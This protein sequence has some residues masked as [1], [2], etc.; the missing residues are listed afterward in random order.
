MNVT[1]PTLSEESLTIS[2]GVIIRRT[3]KNRQHNG[4]NETK[5]E[6][7]M[8]KPYTQKKTTDLAT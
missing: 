1:V 8:T 3:S 5:R 7:A 2:K 4:Q 6:T